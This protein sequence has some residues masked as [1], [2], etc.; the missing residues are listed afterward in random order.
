MS[1]RHSGDMRRSEWVRVVCLALPQ[2]Q[3]SPTVPQTPRAERVPGRS[4]RARSCITITRYFEIVV[5]LL[6][7]SDNV[8]SRDDIVKTGCK[9]GG[10]DIL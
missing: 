10:V 8:L 6:Y 7:I 1:L 2:D 5:Y 4:G 9:F 3:S